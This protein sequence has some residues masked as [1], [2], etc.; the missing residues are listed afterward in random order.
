MEGPSLRFLIV[1]LVDV[2][3]ADQGTTGTNPREHRSTE[4]K[5]LMKW[6]AVAVAPLALVGATGVG[7]AAAKGKPPAVTATGTTTCNFH[8]SLVLHGDG[9]LSLSGNITGHGACSSTG[10]SALKTG[11][12]NQTVPT[13]AASSTT[14]MCT[15]ITAAATAPQT[16]AD[17]SGGTIAWSPGP[18]VVAS[19]GV[20]LSGGSLSS[21]GTTLTLKW[22]GSTVTAGSFTGSGTGLVSTSS[23][24]D[25]VAACAAGPVTSLPVR[26]QLNI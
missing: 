16:V 19:T 22:T 6:A 18:K 11:H 14:D 24:A 9:S 10:G 26:G 25:A 20:G 3:L 13:S 4:M 1:A 15:A 2:G 17:L 23:A 5:H 8:G 12:M 7:M 21:D